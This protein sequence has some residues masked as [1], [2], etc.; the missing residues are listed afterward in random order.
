MLAVAVFGIGLNWP[1]GSTVRGVTV[2]PLVVALLHLLA[3]GGVTI[4]AGGF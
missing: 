2:V 4:W 3:I 1:R